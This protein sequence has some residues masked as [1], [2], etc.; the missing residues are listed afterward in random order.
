MPTVDPEADPST[1]L[2]SF[3]SAVRAGWHAVSAVSEPAP[4][5]LV[6]LT[7]TV[8]LVLVTVRPLW[9]VTRHVIT[10]AHEGSHALVARLVGR[11][12]AGIRLH[13]DTSGVTVSS[14]NPRGPGMIATAFAGYT[15]P[16]V[17]GFVA[18]TLLTV[19]RPAAVLWSVLA[20]LALL[21]LLIRNFFGFVSVLAAGAVIG[22]AAYYGDELVRYTVAYLTTWVLLFGATRPVL[23]LARTHRRGRGHGSDADQLRWLTRVPTAVWIGAFAVVTLG[24]AAYGTARIVA[25]QVP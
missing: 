2:E 8:A 15:G 22:T 1:P 17:L 14:G 24:T 12:L 11:Q 9:L 23:E 20:A 21:I 6:A 10:Q 18:A 16:A 7:A 4:P 25:T 19:D 3:G 5:L 13:S